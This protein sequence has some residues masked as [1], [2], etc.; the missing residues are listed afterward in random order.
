MFSVHITLEKFENATITGH[1]ELCLR[2]TRAK[3]S[4]D[5]RDVIVFEKLRFQKCFPSTLKRKASVFKFL[6]FEQ[7]VLKSSGSDG[8]VW[9][10]GPPVEIALRFDISPAESGWDLKKLSRS[11]LTC[12]E[13]LFCRDPCSQE[14]SVCEPCSLRLWWRLCILCK[15]RKKVF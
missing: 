13:L 10:V 5:Y 7:C 8:S 6:W 12:S 3:K 9:T 11:L 4:R 15:Y 1:F 14:E 2:K